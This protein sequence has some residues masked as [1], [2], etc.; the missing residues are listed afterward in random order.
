[1]DV[2]RTVVAAFGV[3]SSAGYAE[4]APALVAEGFE[5][6]IVCIDKGEVFYDRHDIDDRFG[7]HIFDGGAADMIDSGTVFAKY[8]LIF[9][10]SSLNMVSHSG[11]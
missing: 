1:M 11:R 6:F 5:L 2:V 10:D 7:R 9:L 4:L 8:F 3:E